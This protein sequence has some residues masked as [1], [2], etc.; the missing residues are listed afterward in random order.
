MKKAEFIQAVAEKTGSTKK[1]ATEVVDS[2]LEVISD[3]LVKG[4][5]ISFIGFGSFGL[6]ERAAREGK[7]PGTN[8][9]YKSPATKVVKFK[10]GKQLKEAVAEAAKGS[11]SCKSGKC[12]KK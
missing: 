7:V 3:V 5:S 2:A 12:K 4:D 10:V 9:T 1:V 11:K 8:R 6:A